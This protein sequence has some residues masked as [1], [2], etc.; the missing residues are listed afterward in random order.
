MRH[1]KLSHHVATFEQHVVWGHDGRGIVFEFH[2][3]EKIID[4]TT[5]KIMVA[6]LKCTGCATTVVKEL[7]KLEG[8][9]KVEVDVDHDVVDVVYEDTDRTK[10]IDRL[11]DLG[12]PEAT[13]KN[14]LLLQLKS[15][16]SCMIGRVN[17]M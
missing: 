1:G 15:Y 17:N 5:E 14:G 4:M 10:I 11:H 7:M 6:N 2:K 8:V 16:A 9:R 13:E 12:Y 3:R